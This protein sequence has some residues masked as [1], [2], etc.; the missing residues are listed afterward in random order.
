VGSDPLGGLMRRIGTFVVLTAL[1]AVFAVCAASA[2]AKSSKLVLSTPAGRV[3]SGNPFNLEVN[4][5]LVEFIQTKGGGE[6]ETTCTGKGYLLGSDLTNESSKDAIE[7]TTAGG[8]LEGEAGCFGF[9][10]EGRFEH[11]QVYINDPGPTI[12]TLSLKDASAANTGIAE[13]KAKGKITFGVYFPTPEASCYYGLKK[14]SGSLTNVNAAKT[15]LTFA[16]G[17][18]LKLVKPS[19]THCPVMARFVISVAEAYSGPKGTVVKEVF[20]Q[21][22]N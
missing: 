1:M 10:Y 3:A 5:I 12:G 7:L 18:V 19:A 17:S 14:L 2:V 8:L 16:L 22:I 4:E 6:E 13:F 15:A 21:T 11:S 9:G 20:G